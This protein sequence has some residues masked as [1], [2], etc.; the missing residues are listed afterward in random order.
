MIFTQRAFRDEVSR[1][2]HRDGWSAS[3]RNLERV[4]L[5]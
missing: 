3:L 1:D 2:A 5:G 4:L